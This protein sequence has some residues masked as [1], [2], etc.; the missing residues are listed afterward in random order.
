MFSFKLNQNYVTSKNE[1]LFNK[2]NSKSN[3]YAGNLILETNSAAMQT[4]SL[5]AKHNKNKT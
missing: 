5:V 4:P 3:S 1:F 2:Y